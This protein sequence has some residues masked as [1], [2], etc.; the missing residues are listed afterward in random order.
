ML[1]RSHFCVLLT[2][3]ANLAETTIIQTANPR[4]NHTIAGSY[5]YLKV[6][7]IE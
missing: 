1:L 7:S 6:Q 5:R 4:S 2:A 3:A